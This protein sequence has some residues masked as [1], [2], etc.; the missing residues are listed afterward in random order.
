MRLF[1]DREKYKD[2]DTLVVLSKLEAG[3]AFSSANPEGLLAVA[4]DLKRPDIAKKVRQYIKQKD[5]SEAAPD[6]TEILS[7]PLRDQ[8]GRLLSSVTTLTEQCSRES[9]DAGASGGARDTTCAKGVEG[10]LQTVD[11]LSEVLLKVK[12]EL[13]NCRQEGRV[14]PRVRRSSSSCKSCIS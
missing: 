2:A 6:S 10:A 5:K 14:V 4:K 11:I 8:L 13:K 12:K 1:K 7:E 3:G 9:S